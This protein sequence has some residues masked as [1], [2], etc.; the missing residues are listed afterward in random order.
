[1]NDY[2]FCAFIITYISA[3]YRTCSDLSS[4]LARISGH[5]LHW[6]C[7]YPGSQKSQSS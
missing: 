4:S 3:Q 1:M 5:I 6:G 2:F 7:G